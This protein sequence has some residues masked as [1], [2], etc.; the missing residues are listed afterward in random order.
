MCPL[1][2][3]QLNV[4]ARSCVACVCHNSKSPKLHTVVALRS[5]GLNELQYLARA[6]ACTLT[7]RDTVQHTSR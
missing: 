7:H 5:H 6:H 1:V 3:A 2:V 4:C